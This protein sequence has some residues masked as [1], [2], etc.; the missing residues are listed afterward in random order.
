M[1]TISGETDDN[2]AKA[3]NFKEYLVTSIKH[4]D[5]MQIGITAAAYIREKFDAVDRGW[6]VPEYPDTLYKPPARTDE[7]PVPIGVTAQIVPGSAGG[8]DNAGDGVVENDYSIILNWSHPTTQRTD[9]DGNNL[10]DVYE[11]SLIHI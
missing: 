4:G 11:L 3:G 8:G 2:V 10:T 6:K 7:V 5:D 1:Y 9:S